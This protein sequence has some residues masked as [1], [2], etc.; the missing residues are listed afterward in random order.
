MN[1]QALIAFTFTFIAGG[2][3]AIGAA[4]TFFVKHNNYRVLALG[5]S[6]SAGVMIYLSFMDILPMAI[7]NISGE[8]E[9]SKLGHFAAIAMF[10]IGVFLAG[11]IDY[12]VPEHLH[13]E[14]DK[15]LNKEET[16]G[17]S[18]IEIEENRIS[19]K[20]KRVAVLTALALGIHNF[21]EG[22]SVFVTSFENVA[23]G[24]G[25]AIAIT[26]HNIPEGISV[27]MPIY[28]ATGSKSKAFAIATLS[29]MSEP[30]G[31]I[32][33]YLI[34]APFLSPILT[35]GTLALTAG[36]MVYIALD[37]L[38]PMAREYGE[39]HYGIIGVFCGMGMMSAVDII[40][41]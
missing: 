40:F 8:E 17:T 3:T 16:G 25:V 10:F 34:F 31:A 37:E 36:L 4:L 28:S 32:V 19:K 27:A 12:F 30:L 6:F 7:S 38:L 26:L 21:P 20:A 24:M 9:I 39:E 1:E 15:H 23:V 2:A 33:A 35:G 18:S 41:Q 14:D 13:S 29:G 5:M 22:F 11:I